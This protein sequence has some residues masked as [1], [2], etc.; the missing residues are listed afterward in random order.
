MLRTVSAAR[1]PVQPLVRFRFPRPT[2]SWFVSV[3]P[4]RLVA[5]IVVTLDLGPVLECLGERRRVRETLLPERKLD[6]AEHHVVVRDRGCVALTRVRFEQG[7]KFILV[8][9]DE[10]AL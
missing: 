8:R 1:A 4:T 6:C 5:E 3:P 10:L 2:H 7:V 9:D